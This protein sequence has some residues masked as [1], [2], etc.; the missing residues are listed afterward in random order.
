MDEI[1][2]RTIQ[3]RQARI[4]KE[5]AENLEQWRANMLQAKKSLHSALATVSKL[6]EEAKPLFGPEEDDYKVLFRAR[7]HLEQAYRALTEAEPAHQRRVDSTIGR[8]RQLHAEEDAK[9]RK[10]AE[11][12]EEQGF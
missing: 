4:E 6:E 3:A 5:Q 8:W 7:L 1:L 9:R 2:T 10:A 11:E 12:Q